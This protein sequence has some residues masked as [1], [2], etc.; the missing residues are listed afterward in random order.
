[1]TVLGTL[2]NVL[3]ILALSV[4]PGLLLYGFLEIDRISEWVGARRARLRGVQDPDGPPIERLA[5]DLRRLA[6]VLCAPGPI[7]SVRRHGVERAYDD[8]LIHACRALGITEAIAETTGWDREIERLRAETELERS[9]IVL[10]DP[11]PHHHPG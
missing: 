11:D 4:A 5:E 3:L 2:G 6:A 10:R 9:G 1:M 7:S 8:A